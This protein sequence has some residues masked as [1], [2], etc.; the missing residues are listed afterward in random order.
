[1]QPFLTTMKTQ[2]RFYNS[3]LLRV[4]RE[5]QDEDWRA[6]LQDV[7]TC[8]YHYFS[9]LPALMAFLA[10]ANEPAVF[11]SSETQETTHVD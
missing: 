2:P 10:R 3:Y 11:R 1:M 7:F 4:W 8:E 5:F 9:S 6:S